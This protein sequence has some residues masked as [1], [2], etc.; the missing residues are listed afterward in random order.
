M[1]QDILNILGNKI[2]KCVACPLAKTRINAVPGEGNSKAKIMII[3]EAPGRNEDEQGKPFVG[4]AGKRLNKLLESNGIE[5]KDVFITNVAKCRPPQNRV[6]TEEE[7]KTCINLYL[8][9]QIQAIKPKLIILLGKTASENFLQFPFKEI[10]G[11]FIKQKQF[12]FFPVYHPSAA[13]FTKIKQM[14]EE[15]FAKLK[16]FDESK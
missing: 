16:L 13:R 4:I 15:D 8:N 7:A 12:T 11:K 14:L 10:R 6:P 9:E 1:N 5:R 2:K 3:G